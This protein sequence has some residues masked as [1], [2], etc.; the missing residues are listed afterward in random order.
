[1]QCLAGAD[2]QKVN[3]GVNNRNSHSKLCESET[4][5]IISH[6]RSYKHASEHKASSHCERSK[7]KADSSTP[8]APLAP[9][10]LSWHTITASHLQEQQKEWHHVL[11][12]DQRIMHGSNIDGAP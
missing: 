4:H 9:Y 5:A 11:G 8:G 12:V 2:M 3:K 7:K 1:M 6:G 10:P